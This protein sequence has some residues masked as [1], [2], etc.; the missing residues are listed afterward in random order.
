MLV[1]IG[2]VCGLIL[3]ADLSTAALLG[4]VAMGMLLVGGVPWSSMFRTAG[5]VIALC[6]TIYGVGK[7]APEVFPRFGTWTSRIEQ[8]IGFTTGG[9]QNIPSEGEYQIEL[10]QVAIH[11]GGLLP[12]GPGTGTSRNFL[13]HPY[14]DM[15]YAFIIEEWW[16][17]IVTTLLDTPLSNNKCGTEM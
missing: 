2:L 17:G 3:P 12:S 11:N 13:P 7:V 6:L 8:H 14:S 4:V 10:A 5:I 16:Y 1:R 15:I 9:T